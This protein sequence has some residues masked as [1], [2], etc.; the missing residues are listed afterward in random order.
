[1]AVIETEKTRAIVEGYFDAIMS[2]DING[3]EA[4]LDFM[5]EDVVWE[6]PASIKQGGLFHGKA[7]VRKLLTE[8]IGEV[9]EPRSMRNLGRRSIAEGNRAVTIY[10]TSART[11]KG[12]DYRQHFAIEFEVDAAGKIKF[13]RENFDTLLFETVV[14]GPG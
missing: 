12:R 7:A 6:N 9:Y 13:I 11:T 4:A 1:M 3:I 2:V 14:Y 10:D 8:A 5:T